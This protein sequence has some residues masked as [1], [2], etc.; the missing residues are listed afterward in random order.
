MWFA[1]SRFS[2]S[3]RFILNAIWN[4]H[5]KGAKKHFRLVPRALLRSATTF[6]LARHRALGRQRE[7]DTV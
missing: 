4:K 2:P 3:I 6:E 1:Q 7:L 5:T